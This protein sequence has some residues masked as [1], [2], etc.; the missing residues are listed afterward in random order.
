MGISSSS[1]WDIESYDQELFMCY[2][3]ADIQRFCSVL[4][5]GPRDLFAID[6]TSSPITPA[7]LAGL[8]RDHCHSHSIS[9]EQFE[10]ASGWSIA[11]SLDEP[12]R[13]RHDYPI[14]GIRDICQELAVDWDRFM[15]SQ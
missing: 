5:I 11:K 14:D 15:V 3:T 7:E 10:D 2:S 8:I 9:I 6:S 4:A 1:I 13:F 12:E